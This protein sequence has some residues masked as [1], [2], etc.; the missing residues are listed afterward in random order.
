V[1]ADAC[2]IDD[3]GPVPVVRP[4]TPAELGEVVRVAGVGQQPGVDRRVQRLDPA[5]QAL[6]EPGQLPDLGHRDAGRPQ[7]PRG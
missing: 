3:F 6:A 2:T 1:D 4:T 5:V 7:H